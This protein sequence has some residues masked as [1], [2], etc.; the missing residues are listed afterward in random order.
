MPQSDPYSVLGLS[1]GAS[2]DEVT[3]AYRKLAKKYHPDLNPGDE[4]AA[5]RMAEVNAAYDSIMNGTPYG[6]RA[7]QNPYTQRSSSYGPSGQ[8]TYTTGQGTYTYTG[9]YGS[10]RQGDQYYD[11]FSDFFREWQKQAEQQQYQQTQRTQRQ[12]A[13]SSSNGGYQRTYRRTTSHADS[14]A[15]GCLRWAAIL[16]VLNLVLNILLGGCSYLSAGMMGSGAFSMNGSGSSEESPYDDSSNGSDASAGAGTDVS[17]TYTGA[18]S[19][20]VGS[21]QSA[22]TSV[23]TTTTGTAA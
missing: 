1:P 6:P 2:K 12:T 22:A 20:H 10:N 21:V 5:K 15:G 14:Q 23:R 8:R 9:G 19:V 16:I 13:S 4:Q 7:A 17:Y 3:K 18:S 11:P